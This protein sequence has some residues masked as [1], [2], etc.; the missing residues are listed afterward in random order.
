MKYNQIKKLCA[1]FN[2]GYK[3][4]EPFAI[5]WGLGN[6]RI[7]GVIDEI[8]AL[9]KQEKE[10]RQ[11]AN[12][13]SVAFMFS[14]LFQDP[15]NLRQL[16]NQH[17][18]ELTPEGLKV[19]L[20]W[21]KNPWFWCY[22]Q[23]KEELSHNFWKIE[24]I[25]TGEEHIFYSPY[26]WRL[27]ENVG[28]KDI[29]CFSMMFSNGTCMQYIGVI[30][31]YMFP[32]SD[33]KFFCSTIAPNENLKTIQSRHYPTFLMLDLLMGYPILRYENIELGFSFHTFTL[34]DFS[35]ERL[36]GKWEITSLKS[37]QRFSLLQH[38][39]SMLDLPNV[40]LFI[41]A[42]QAM[43]GVIFR[44]NTTGEMAIHTVSV[45]AYTFWSALLQRAYPNLIFPVD[46]EIF[47]SVHL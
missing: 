14:E 24:D 34:K 28:R 43:S 40:E 33:F 39:E 21:E 26:I 15:E 11:M 46:P 22:F 3:D 16:I 29:C 45:F 19:L 5:Q 41:T 17:K 47:I 25:L 12:N 4:I 38:D 30:K 23:V 37:V 10:L 20:F 36:G 1:T 27:Q 18:A 42:N 7:E 2:K 9:A 44:D 13:N 35:I 6:K 8:F 32:I 31:V